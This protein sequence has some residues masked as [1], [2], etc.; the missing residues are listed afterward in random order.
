MLEKI[1]ATGTKIGA[2]DFNIDIENARNQGE[3]KQQEVM[4]GIIAD[5][6]IE[7]KDTTEV[8]GSEFENK[9]ASSTS[10][11]ERI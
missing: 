4:I 10:S 6:T 1:T 2:S 8:F 5:L 7:M 3:L 9:I 11:K